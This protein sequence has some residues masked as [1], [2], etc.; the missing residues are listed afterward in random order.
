[1][2]FLGTA[3]FM[4]GCSVTTASMGEDM[5]VAGRASTSVFGVCAGG[6]GACEYSWWV[7]E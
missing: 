3:A 4:N 1:M 5:H 2:P 7:A 6:L